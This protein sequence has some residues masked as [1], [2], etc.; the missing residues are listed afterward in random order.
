M[1]FWLEV[2]KTWKYAAL[3]L[4]YLLLKI[5][6]PDILTVETRII[7]W[8]ILAGHAD[9]R[10]KQAILKAN[11]K[12]GF[13]L[14]VRCYRSSNQ[15]F[16]SLFSGLIDAHQESLHHYQGCLREGRGKLIQQGI[17]NKYLL[18]FLK[19]WS[20]KSGIWFLGT[21]EKQ[22]FTCINNHREPISVT[23]IQISIKPP[24]VLQLPFKGKA[25]PGILW[26]LIVWS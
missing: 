14:R 17:F 21:C 11:W 19:K 6:V 20:Y 4:N 18:L 9:G 22:R 23:C 15:L 7:S 25:D 10:G 24:Q 26:E 13:V 3:G 8:K 12:F 1:G 2:R 16:W 5:P